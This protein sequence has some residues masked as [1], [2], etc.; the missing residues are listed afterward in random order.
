MAAAI[1]H[2]FHVANHE[3]VA[4]GVLGLED[5]EL[6]GDVFGATVGAGSATV[7]LASAGTEMGAAA[8]VM[9]G[10]GTV[11]L[12]VVCGA[13]TV[14]LAGVLFVAEPASAA[15]GG[16]VTVTVTV[17]GGVDVAVGVF[18]VIVVVG[19]VGFVIWRSC[20]EWMWECRVRAAIQSPSRRRRV[21]YTG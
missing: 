6:V 16:T 3:G 1:S 17:K 19:L 4:G 11:G 13:S 5:G 18:G 14:T 15:A 9:A 12:A 2:F 21:R 7:G 20:L 8:A 10:A